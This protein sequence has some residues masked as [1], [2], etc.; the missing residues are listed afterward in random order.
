M[1]LPE[2]C[3]PFYK[4]Y[5]YDLIIYLFFLFHISLSDQKNNKCIKKKKKYKTTILKNLL[6]TINYIKNFIIAIILK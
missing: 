3:L 2:N 4:L 6:K 1:T 5:I